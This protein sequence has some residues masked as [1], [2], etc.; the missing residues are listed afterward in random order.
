MIFNNLMKS[1]NLQ[2]RIA[3]FSLAIV[4]LCTGMDGQAGSNV[5]T[6][7]VYDHTVQ[8]L[9]WYQTSAECR[10]LYY[11]AFNTARLMLDNDLRTQSHTK[12]RAIVFDIDET[13]LDDSPHS[14]MLLK[15]NKLFPYRYDE[16]LMASIEPP[17]PGAVEFAQYASSHGVDLFYISNREARMLD[18]TVRNLQ[19]AGFPQSEESHVLLMS[20]EPSK[21]GRRKTVAASHEI[22]LLLGDNLNDLSNVFE[23][24]SIDE[25]F[26]ETDK[27][28][29]EFG[30]RYIV[31][32]N[33]VYGAWETAIYDNKSNL[34]EEQKVL[35]RKAVLRS[36]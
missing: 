7:S 13:I 32:P 18:A 36:F 35:R 22:I 20:S 19:A 16:W 25:R 9:A 4:V 31:L 28:R 29:S 34:S 33:P 23:R 5:R 8:A 21:E 3:V 6:A 12:K 27:A 17:L 14:A 30:S 15:E 26:A 11:Q 1:Q 24:K 10:A 2:Y